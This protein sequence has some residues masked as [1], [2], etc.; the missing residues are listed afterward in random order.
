[1]I[2]SFQLSDQRKIKLS[3]PSDFKIASE[4]PLDAEERKFLTDETIKLINKAANVSSLYI[5]DFFI[6]NSSAVLAIEDAC[7]KAAADLDTLVTRKF[8]ASIEKKAAAKRV[9]LTISANNGRVAIFSSTLNKDY[10]A[11][12]IN[13]FLYK[14]HKWKF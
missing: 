6:P 1:M 10:A 11:N 4:G 2:V 14:N 7:I 5:M 3:Y 13:E 8:T 9:I 12:K